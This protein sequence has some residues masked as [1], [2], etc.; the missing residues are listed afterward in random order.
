[1]NGSTDSQSTR[2]FSLCSFFIQ[3]EVERVSPKS[4]PHRF[5]GQHFS[6]GI[7]AQ[8]DIASDQ[9][10]K[11]EVLRFLRSLPNKFLSRYLR[12]YFL[13]QSLPYFAASAV[14]TNVPRFSCF[15]NYIR[16]TC[17]QFCPH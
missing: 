5:M 9:L 6:W 1:M 4:N 10:N 2:T 13:Y 8:V 15:G 16:R 14:N 7:V 17:T 12:K 3:E 11:I